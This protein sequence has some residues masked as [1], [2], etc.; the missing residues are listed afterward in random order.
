MNNYC[1]IPQPVEFEIKCPDSLYIEANE[2]DIKHL[3]INLIKNSI[4]EMVKSKIDFDTRVITIICQQDSHNVSF[5]VED[6]GKGIPDKILPNIFDMNFTTK[7]NSGGTG[8]GLFMC[9]QIVQKYKGKISV[10]NKE[11]SSGAS[12]C[13]TL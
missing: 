5:V 12:F 8:V 11:Q 1:R 9:K 7:Q 6:S 2:N 3:F 4:D 13:I 10:T